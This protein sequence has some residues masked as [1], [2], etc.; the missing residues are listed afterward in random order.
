MCENRLYAQNGRMEDPL[1]SDSDCLWEA[2]R[3]IHA[4]PLNPNLWPLALAKMA[5]AVS[6]SKGALFDLDAETRQMVA[7]IGNAHDPA[8]Q[9]RYV[10]RYAAIDPTLAYALTAPPLEPMV[11]Y[12][13]FPA[14]GQVERVEKIRARLVRES[15]L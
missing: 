11:C 14:R 6:A 7:L 8:V 5:A 3:E 1:A 10:Q 4:A 2:V 13:R 12:E 9:E 15:G